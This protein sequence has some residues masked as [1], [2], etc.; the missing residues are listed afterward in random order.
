MTK[1]QGLSLFELVL[2]LA[3]L[4]ITLAIALPSFAQLAQKNQTQTNAIILADAITTARALAVMRNKRSLLL[5][6]GQWQQ[7][8]SLFV[9]INSNGVQDNNEPLISHQDRLEG[10]K[11][12][13]NGYLRDY[14][15]FIGTGEGRSDGNGSESGAFIAGSLKICSDT[16]GPGIKLVLSRGGR[17]RMTDLTAEE[18]AEI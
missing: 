5:A 11:I 10:V 7:G 1:N 12:K 16:P 3:I 4:S 9:D 17:L 2:T 6:K 8:W 13:G 15:S 14:V 18:C